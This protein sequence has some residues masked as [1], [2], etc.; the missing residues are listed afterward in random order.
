[1]LRE[2]PL[3]CF[4][5][6]CTYPYGDSLCRLSKVKKGQLQTHHMDSTLKRRGNGRFH[7]VSMWNSRGVFLGDM[8]KLHALS[9]DHL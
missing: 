6:L 3:I 7:I 8:V 5:L 4:Y 1:M 2:W 9:V